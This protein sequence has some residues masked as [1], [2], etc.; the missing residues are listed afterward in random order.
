MPILYQK[1]FSLEHYLS[2]LLQA[3][4][5]IYMHLVFVMYTS[6][7][8]FATDIFKQNNEEAVQEELNLEHNLAFQ[9]HQ[10]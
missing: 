3:I 1:K 8:N 2:S 9:W 10:D 7:H 5:Y 4:I 6:F